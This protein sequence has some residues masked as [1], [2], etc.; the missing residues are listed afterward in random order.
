M[1]DE[2]VR[3]PDPADAV[4]LPDLR[5]P[6]RVHAEDAQISP[7]RRLRFLR[8]TD[9][10]RRC[11]PDQRRAYCPTHP[12]SSPSTT[13]RSSPTV[14][15]SAGDHR[16]ATTS[17]FATP[18]YGSH[19][20][21]HET[22]HTFGLP[23]LYTYSKPLRRGAPQ[24]RRLGPDGLDRSRPRVQRL[25]PPEARLARSGAG[26]LRRRRGDRDAHAAGDG[27]RQRRC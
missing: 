19:V 25:A 17:A 8:P 3:M 18:D 9:P 27:R 4:H 2:W 22:G 5:W 20:L 15:E 13:R 7:I 6:A 14:H 11:G 24:R 26:G 12:H 1:D 16:S 10:L 21:A 23:D